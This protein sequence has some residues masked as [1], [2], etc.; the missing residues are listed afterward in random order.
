MNIYQHHIQVINKKTKKRNRKDKKEETK[1]KKQNF[2]SLFFQILTFKKII[3]KIQKESKVK[4][5]KHK[6]K[7]KWKE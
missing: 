6:K 3:L 7:R 4:K 5:R 2:Q 1:N